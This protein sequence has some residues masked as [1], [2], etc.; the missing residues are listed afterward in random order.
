MNK[1]CLYI[2]HHCGEEKCAGIGCCWPVNQLDVKSS[3]LPGAESLICELNSLYMLRL[4]QY[5]QGEGQ[6]GI[7][8]LKLYLLCC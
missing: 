5:R 4:I 8:S 3:F 6:R 2:Y 1:L 7:L